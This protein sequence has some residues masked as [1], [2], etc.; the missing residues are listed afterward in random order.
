M[1]RNICQKFTVTINFGGDVIRGLA[2][3]KFYPIE[4][5]AQFGTA[6]FTWL[7]RL[8]ILRVAIHTTIVPASAAD[9]LILCGMP[10]NCSMTDDARNTVLARE[11]WLEK[12]AHHRHIVEP[13]VSPRLARRSLGQS[14]PVDDFLFEYYPVSPNKLMTW[15]PGFGMTLEAHADDSE[16]FPQSAYEFSN[17]G[18]HIRHSWITQRVE[19]IAQTYDFLN[20]TAQR[21]ARTGCFGLHEWAM[22]L[23]P[24]EVRHS[25]WKLR[26]S[27]D[28][29]R[30]TIDDVGLKCTHFDAFRFFTPIARPLNPIQLTRADQ[31]EYDQPGCLHANM[32]LYKYAQK[33]A[34]IV[35]SSLIRD[36][37][38]LARDIRTVD[39]QVAPYDLADLGVEPIQVETPEGRAAFAAHQVNFS[40]RAV[41]LRQRLVAALEPLVD[42]S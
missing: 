3:C 15:H 22:V 30:A 33:F 27:Q 39:M 2:R 20:I 40:E 25:S 9:Y 10:E 36:T 32:D 1:R 28:E 26:L 35:G 6:L 41:A 5:C 17:G 19:R 13:W 37:F 23:G 11:D 42:L 21:P 18:I 8:S 4:K 7:H 29:I 38:A 16:L 12:S 31:S 14:H 24:D 34:P